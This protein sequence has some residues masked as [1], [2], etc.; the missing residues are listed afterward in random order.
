MSVEGRRTAGDTIIEVLIAIAVSASVIALTYVT[1]NKNSAITRANQERIQATRIAQS[2]IELLRVEHNAVQQTLAAPNAPFCFNGDK[3]VELPL[4]AVNDSLDSDDYLLYGDQTTG[5]RDND[6]RVGIKG[7]VSDVR[8]YIVYVRWDRTGGRSKV[9][10][11]NRDEV[12]V[13]YRVGL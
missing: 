9:I 5:C 1:M 3:I 12:R 7:D 13:T 2:Q 4:G 10:N 8:Q 6:Y 11:E